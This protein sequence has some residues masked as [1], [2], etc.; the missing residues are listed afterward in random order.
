MAVG[1]HRPPI[2]THL[3]SFRPRHN[4]LS[5]V[6]CCWRLCYGVGISDYANNGKITKTTKDYI[7]YGLGGAVAGAVAG[8]GGMA[9]ASKATLKTAMA[10]GGAS[11]MAGDM[12]TQFVGKGSINPL[13]AI[14]AGV[15]GAVT[16]GAFYG[17]SKAVGSIKNS[18][19]SKIE[20]EVG[21]QTDSYGASKSV[22]SIKNN[23]VSKVEKEGGLK[24]SDEVYAG[25]RKASEYLKS[26]GV[27]RQF[28]K[29]I[30]ESFD[31]RTINME[32][33]GDS[34][35]AIRFYGGN[36]KAEGR[37]LFETFS[38]LTNR[39]YLALPYE[40]N[41]MTGIQQFQVK[42]GTSMITGNAAGQTSFGSQYVGGA[43]QW[44]INSLEDLIK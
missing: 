14:K 1:Y 20:K 41:S 38:P 42:S 28:R 2:E 22:G 43:K 4:H 23:L 8:V 33:A 29:Q 30:L 37:Y 17:A 21:S 39:N 19:I 31:V 3:G 13:Q 32:T 9:L 36:A 12:T 7:S 10:I 40:W 27:P 6:G 5:I 26:Q 35:F 25:V 16:A 18:S 34:T 15:V 24:T 44:Y 11:S